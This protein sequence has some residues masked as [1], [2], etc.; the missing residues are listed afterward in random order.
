MTCGRC[1]WFILSEEIG[2]RPLSIPETWDPAPLSRH[3]LTL[4]ICIHVK[5]IR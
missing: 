4:T 5:M 2:H 1:E 3:E